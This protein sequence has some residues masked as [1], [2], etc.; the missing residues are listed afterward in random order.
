MIDRPCST[1]KTLGRPLRAAFCVISVL[2]WAGCDSN[3]GATLRPDASPEARQAVAR[4]ECNRCHTALATLEPAPHDKNCSGCHNAILDGEYDWKFWKYSSEQVAHWKANITHL[5]DVPTLT[6][7]DQR[8]ERDWL[9]EFLR[10]PHDLRPRLEAT[11]PRLSMPEQDARLIAE[12]FFANAPS[13]APIDLSDA[14]L[15]AGREAMNEQ[16]CGLC[17][18]FGGAEPLEAS[19]GSFDLEPEQLARA[20]ALAPDLRHTR[21]RMSAAAVVAWLE[22]PAAVKPDTLMPQIELSA[23]ERRNVAAYILEA[24]LLPTEPPQIP[25]RLP[26]LERE[27][28]YGEVEA[29]VFKKV[30]WHCHSDPAGNNG[31]GGPGN[32]GGFGFA[33]RGLDLGTHQGL[34]RGRLDERGERQSVLEPTDDGT[35]RLVAHLLARHSEVAGR[36]SEGVRGMPLGLPP[37]SMERI[38]LVET[39]IAQGAKGPSGDDTA[40]N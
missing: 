34:L 26:I 1:H 33:G 22:D 23:S 20:I 31:D 28:T 38:Q 5:V 36:P 24:D 16:A 4:Y 8:F 11:M 12:Y 7:I 2:V 32:T 6:G 13:R 25:K 18:R 3:T 35:P 27:V 15:Q 14:D 19:A 37:L 40:R 29:R 39:W 17:H 21:A 10:A 30:C 9:V